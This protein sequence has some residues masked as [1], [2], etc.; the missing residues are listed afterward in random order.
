MENLN[1]KDKINA[2]DLELL[3]KQRSEREIHFILID[4]REEYEYQN[5]RI[6]GVDYLIPMSNIYQLTE[7]I[8]RHKDDIIILQ[9]KSGGR[10]LQAQRY[11]NSLG[12]KK[13][14]NMEG[15]IMAYNGE[16]DRG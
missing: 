11:L 16:K 6:V 14:I 9:C 2:P 13:T 3:L 15:G 12:F 4:V 10:S 1:T 5:E 7:S 8:D